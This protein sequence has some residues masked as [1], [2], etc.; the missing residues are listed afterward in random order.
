M[1]FL[2][3]K[4]ALDVRAGAP[5]NGRGDDN[6]TPVKQLWVGRESYPYVSAQAFRRW[7]RD[8]VPAAEARSGVKRSG[9][10]KNQQAYTDGRPDLYF[11]DDMFGYM[12]AVK[13]AGTCQRD[14]VFATG[15]LLS[16]APRRPTTDFGTMSRDFGAGE[17]PVIHEH[18]LY[19]AELAADVLLDL[20]RI[21]TFETDGSG[22]KVAL[23]EVA[24]K[25]A[26]AGGADELVF[27]GT[28]ALRLPLAERR[29]RGALLLRTLTAVRGGAK[30]A[31]HYGDRT[32]SLV[33]LAPV[34]GGINPFSRVLAE[35]GGK[36]VFDTDV[37][38]EEIAAWRDELDGPVHLGW[39]PGFLGDQRE[40]ARA[41]LAAELDAEVLVI[42]HPRVVFGRLADEI[43]TGLR[44]IWFD[45]P[46]P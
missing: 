9:S 43:E 28:A 23:T 22:L 4:I 2:A 30:Q 35:R 7:L 19:S 42:D 29:R 20:P 40:K 6:V 11:D 39:A 10:G 13:G 37:L 18:Q 34:K 46:T 8:S 14:T 32:P 38:R 36:V 1:T 15:T 5:N 25:D 44:D 17:N 33:L 24:A 31:L 21:G 45:D 12:V 26:R 16:V 27:R 41:E 3:G